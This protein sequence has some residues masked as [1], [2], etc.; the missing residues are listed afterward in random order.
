[1]PSTSIILPNYNHARFLP[2]RIESILDQSFADFELIILD[3]CSTDNSKEIIES[4]K[5]KDKR[6]T[7]HYN[8]ENSGSPF[9]QWKKG[10]DMASGEFIW[11]AESDD[12]AGPELLERLLEALKA[13]P[14]AGVAYCQSNF[15]NSDDVIIGNHIENLKVLHPTLWE[16]D[17]CM[18]GKEVLARFMPVINVIPNIGAAVF[19]KESIKDV[20]WDKLFSYKLAGD[21]YFWINLL[22]KYDLCFVKDPLNYFRM[23]GKTVRSTNVHTVSYLKEIKSVIFEIHSR[24][25]LPLKIKNQA[26]RQ[27]LRHFRSSAGQ[28]RHGKS[29]PFIF[30][31]FGVFL[32]LMMIYFSKPIPNSKPG[33]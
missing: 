27:W 26:I 25:R 8:A 22:S 15:V 5:Q 16:S 14:S 3:D 13:N 33:S 10:I 7:T 4:Y 17:F 23:D 29:L 28:S 18:P 1:M 32:G 9:R 21:R 2:R 6:I 11:I 31:S 19:R 12:Y 30:K 24:V 20:D